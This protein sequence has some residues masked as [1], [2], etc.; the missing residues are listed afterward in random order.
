MRFETT[1]K[2]AVIPG[3]APS[4]VR[5]CRISVEHRH[6]PAAC[7][8]PENSASIC[9]RAKGTEG[10]KT[11]RLKSGPRSTFDHILRNGPITLA[12][13]PQLIRP[14]S[15]ICGLVDDN[16]RVKAGQLVARV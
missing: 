2:P 16:Q 6:E 15:D 13:I 7:R 5:A 4:Q 12:E 11:L 9:A 8:R 14:A 10:C 3:I 1:G